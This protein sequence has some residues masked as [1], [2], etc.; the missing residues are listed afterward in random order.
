MFLVFFNHDLNLRDPP[1][2]EPLVVLLCPPL[3]PVLDSLQAFPC[4]TL[5]GILI[6]LSLAVA[7][8]A[9]RTQGPFLGGRMS[10][11]KSPPR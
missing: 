7:E 1:V 9:A 8:I 10:G 6:E 5:L 11:L 4:P 2:M 3:F